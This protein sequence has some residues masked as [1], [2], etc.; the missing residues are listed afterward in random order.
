MVEQDAITR[1]EAISLSVIDG[2][3]ICIDLGHAIRGA[4][5]ERR[6]FRLWRLGHPAEHLRSRC[7]VE[8][9]A[10]LKLEYANCFQ[11]PERADR[12]GVR[13]ILRCLE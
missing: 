11:N 9:R 4:R 2:Y 7:L 6:R 10:V 12:V 5:I 3:P 13:R 1:I 8:A